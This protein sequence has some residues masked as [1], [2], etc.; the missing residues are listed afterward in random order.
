MPN[1]DFVTRFFPLLRPLPPLASECRRFRQAWGCAPGLLLG[2]LLGLASAHSWAAETETLVLLQALARAHAAVVGI[3]TTIPQDARSAATLGRTRTGSGVVIAPDGLILT[4]G[5]LTLEADQVNITT[6]DGVQAAGRVLGY[7]VATG[8]SLVQPILPLPGLQAVPLG[9]PTR[10]A[11]GDAL[12]TAHLDSD[13][14]ELSSMS[15]ARLIRRH[16]FSA[17]W[18]YHLDGA[19]FTTPPMQQHSGAPLFN[20]QGELLGI[21]SLRMQ[22]AATESNPLP[23]NMFVPIDLLLPIL[24]EM[25][26]SGSSK[27]SHRPWLGLTS[28]EANARIQL[29]A[30]SPGG[31][32]QTAGLGV[33]DLILAVDD[34]KVRSLERFYKQLWSHSEVS[35]PIKLTVLQGADLKTVMIGVVE[36]RSTL[37]K[38]QGL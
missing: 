24:Q 27:Q 16:A 8:F 12:V 4:I 17:S 1:T 20:Q 14:V 36:R 10:L 35:Q 28:S 5:Y 21:G 34:V 18:E 23:G 3:Q 2:L 9:N 7:D 22:N 33:G 6:R 29:I 15:T 13:N 30:V 25:Q 26:V 19:L 32:A 11:P 31:P 38:P 37:H